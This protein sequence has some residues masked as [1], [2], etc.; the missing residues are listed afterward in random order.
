MN[1]ILVFPFLNSYLV[2]FILTG[3][4]NFSELSSQWCIQI[5]N[6][7]RKTAKARAVIALLYSRTYKCS[8]TAALPLSSAAD[9][10]AGIRQST[11]PGTQPGLR[12][13]ED[14]LISSLNL[15]VYLIQIYEVYA[16]FFMWSFS[17]C[18]FILFIF[19]NL[20]KL[21]IQNITFSLFVLTPT[22]SFVALKRHSG[23]TITILQCANYYII[24]I[25]FN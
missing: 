5:I 1:D 25:S 4:F 20:I 17:F 23:R 24:G 18:G 16:I 12:T 11:V 21:K 19:K 6:L 14:I 10:A 22:M 13:G 3:M 7:V 8:R 9:S 15:I 2:S